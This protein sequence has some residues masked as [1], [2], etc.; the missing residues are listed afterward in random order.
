LN[1]HRLAISEQLEWT[2][3]GVKKSANSSVKSPTEGL[4]GSIP[5]IGSILRLIFPGKQ[6]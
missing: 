1:E 4:A 6:I 2:P 3:K 5:A